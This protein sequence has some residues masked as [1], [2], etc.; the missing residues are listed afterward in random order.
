MLYVFI[1]IDHVAAL[2]F[3][4]GSGLRGIQEN[5]D[6]L[7]SGCPFFALKNCQTD[8]I[9]VART[10]TV[11]TS[12]VQTVNL[13]SILSRKFLYMVKFHSCPDLAGQHVHVQTLNGQ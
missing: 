9:L 8:A 7:G 1:H 6:C 10:S 3:S 11:C 4:V 2:D 5:N 13:V 12:Y